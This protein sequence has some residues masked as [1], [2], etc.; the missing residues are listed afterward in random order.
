MKRGA[1]LINVGRGAH[2]DEAAL[3]QAINDGQ[4]SGACLDVFAQEP[5]DALSPL[6][7]HPKVTITPHV[8]SYWVDSG[9]DQVAELC[10]QVR[11]GNSIANLVDLKL[12]Y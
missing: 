3:I 2:V 12:G 5:L 11:S 10:R 4:L 7:N 9:I 8:A 6:W 1:Y